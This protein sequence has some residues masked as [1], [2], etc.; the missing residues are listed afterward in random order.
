M[1]YSLELRIVIFHKT[2]L[3][4]QRLNLKYEVDCFR[5]KSY[6]FVNNKRMR[7]SP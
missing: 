7:R 6:S 5:F 4:D 3:N 2:L 1:A